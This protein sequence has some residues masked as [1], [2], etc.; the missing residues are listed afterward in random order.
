MTTQSFSTP[1]KKLIRQKWIKPLLQLISDISGEKLLYFGLPGAEAEDIDDWIEF[2]HIVF[3]F[4]DEDTRYP[5]A[6]QKLYDKLESLERQKK[7]RSF[8][9]FDG[10][11]ERVIMEGFDSQ[12][13]EFNLSEIVTLYNLDFCNQVDFPI[14]SQTIEGEPLIIGKFDAIKRLLEIQKGINNLSTKFVLFLT[15]HCSYNDKKTK[16]HF[17]SPH[18]FSKYVSETN[19]KLKGK[20]DDKNARSLRLYIIEHLSKYFSSAGFIGDFLP[21]IFYEG[22]G[23]TQMLLFTIIGTKME[24]EVPN[25]EID[26]EGLIKSKFL[27][28]NNANTGFENFTRIELNEQDNYFNNSVELFK[29]TTTFK[30]YWQNNA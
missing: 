8:S 2:L 1:S 12:N 21:T 15:I 17:D 20:G 7:I 27:S 18:Q 22:L 14:K 11:M 25:Q 29:E 10:Y 6:Y 23:N 13:R 3:A 24:N 4:Q 26:T 5:N 9:V 19:T 16:S 30:N 28:P